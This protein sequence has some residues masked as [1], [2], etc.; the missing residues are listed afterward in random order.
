M[1]SGANL[2]ISHG[3]RFSNDNNLVP[4]HSLKH[5]LKITKSRENLTVSHNLQTTRLFLMVL[6]L[7]RRRQPCFSLSNVV[8]KLQRITI[9]LLFITKSQNY[10]QW[11]QPYSSCYK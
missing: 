8:S 6:E 2:I 11:R 7:Q 3:F 4:S 9:T 5:V 1:K 10:K